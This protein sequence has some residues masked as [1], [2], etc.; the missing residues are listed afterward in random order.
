MA[1]ARG[2]AYLRMPDGAEV[3]VLFTNRALADA[4]RVTGKPVMQLIQGVDR[5]G[6][7]DTAAL[8]NVGM[9]HAR[10]ESHAGGRSYTLNDAWHVLEAVGFLEA[11]RVVYE[12]VSQVVAWKPGQEG[13][14]EG[15]RPLAARQ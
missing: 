3:A 2:E 12:A 13:E 5:I 6:M 1:G 15:E 11:A 7:G 8:L 4:E 14:N 10:R 9:E